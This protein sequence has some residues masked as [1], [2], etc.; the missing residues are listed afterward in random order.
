MKKKTILFIVI[1]IFL[2]IGLFL[3]YGPYSY[4]RELL[5]TTA[6]TTKE[7]Q[8]LARTVYSDQTISKVLQSNYVDEFEEDTN[9]DEIEFNDKEVTVYDSI[10]EEQILKKDP[11]NEDYK[12][13]PVKG[14]NY[15]GYITV[16]Y[17]PS[18]ITLAFSKYLGNRGQSLKEIAKNNNAKV[19]INASGFLDVNWMGNGG[20][21]T[22]SIIHEGKI[23]NY[24]Q[25]G[26]GG[27]IGFNDKNVLMLLRTS[28]E[29]ALR[30]GIKE[31]VEFGPFLIVNGK[32]AFIKGNGGWGIAP[33]T[34]IAQRKDGIVL[35]VTIDGRQPG[36]SI[37][38]DMVELTK[39]LVRY[40]AHN[41]ANL[42]GGSSTG[43]IVENKIYNRPVASGTEGL[44]DIPNAWILK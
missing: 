6:M 9:T 43:L 30:Q 13:I 3:T 11:N 18:K 38:I 31:A 32:P 8:Y 24:D 37:G 1:D 15:S 42:D 14:Y 16:I 22:G 34:A 4:L 41:A 10:Y 2:L 27:I 20:T 44:R 26:M 39:L 29:E 5:I 36:H 23:Y 21:P 33:R 35:F 25:P 40:K 17:D 7:H 28:A 19:A 12:I